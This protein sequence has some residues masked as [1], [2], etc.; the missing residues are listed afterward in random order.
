MINDI[1]ST[2]LQNLS[3]FIVGNY[4]LFTYLYFLKEQTTYISLL[5]SLN[6][7]VLKHSLIELLTTNNYEIIIYRFCTTWFCLYYRYTKEELYIFS[8]TLLYTEIP[9]IFSVL[10]EYCRDFT[11]LYNANYVLLYLTFF[12][13]KI[14]DFY[15]I[16]HNHKE[17]DRIEHDYENVAVVGI[18]IQYIFNLYWIL[19][20]NKDIYRRLNPYI[21][22]I[23]IN[24]KICKYIHLLNIPL[25]IYMYSF[26]A[27][28]RYIYDVIGIT[29]LS[30][31][32]YQYH[33]DI[34][35]KLK[36]ESYLAEKEDLDNLLFETVCVHV[37]CFL[38]ILTNYYHVKNMFFIV[39]VSGGFHMYSIFLSNMNV[40]Q[41]YVH[42]CNTKVFIKCHRIILAVP[43]LCDYLLI[44]MNSPNEIAIP[45]LLI[46]IMCGL[47]ILVNPFDKLNDVVFQSLLVGQT[48]YCC[49]SNLNSIY[50]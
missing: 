43:V 24:H 30:I 4:S 6:Y 40:L 37:R 16:I 44:F 20:M 35:D 22:R 3:G 25:T 8:S 29:L 27:C 12:K 28:T 49:L 39:V 1:V 21:N 42:H 50:H 34:Y 5:K 14:Y 46:N 36:G 38:S 11:S 23:S 18:Y 31:S 33:N 41:L 47:L 26:N 45:F 48:Y 17:F 32:S 9:T 2:T 19:L 10:K 15:T 13:F 7:Y